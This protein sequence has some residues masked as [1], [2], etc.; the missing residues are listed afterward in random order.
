MVE[1]PF[2]SAPNKRRKSVGDKRH[3]RSIAPNEEAKFFLSNECYNKYLATV[4]KLVT[5]LKCWDLQVL[6]FK[7]LRSLYEILAH[8][9]LVKFVCF[10][11]SCYPR[12]VKLFYANLG[13]SLG[14]L[15]CYVMNKRIVLDIATMV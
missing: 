13:V 2:T 5:P 3:A 7:P 12:L 4:L 6:Q 10:D 15:S 14:K 11:A 1:I 9:K 8:Y